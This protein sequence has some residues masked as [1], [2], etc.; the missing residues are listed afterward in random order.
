MTDHTDLCDLWLWRHSWPNWIKP[1]VTCAPEQMLRVLWGWWLPWAG[2][3]RVSPWGLSWQG[4]P[5]KACPTTP[6]RS[7]TARVTGI[8]PAPKLA[9]GMSLGQAGPT[10]EPSSEGPMVRQGRTVGSCSPALLWPHWGR[11]WQ[12][13][14]QAWW[15]AG[16]GRGGPRRAGQGQSGLWQRSGP[17]QWPCFE[18]IGLKTF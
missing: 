16:Q 9:M 12:S 11:G 3:G 6:A 2:S 8:T 17:K 4:P 14:G 18:Q 15:R 10:V 1:W 5:T 7:R 13:W